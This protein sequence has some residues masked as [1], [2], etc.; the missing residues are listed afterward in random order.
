MNEFDFRWALMV[1][2]LL[3]FGLS[4]AVLALGRLAPPPAR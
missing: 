1:L 4:F 2:C 3:V